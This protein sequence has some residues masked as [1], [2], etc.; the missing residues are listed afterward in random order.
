[1]QMLPPQV[2]LD[3]IWVIL[4]LATLAVALLTCNRRTAETARSNAPKAALR[5][6]ATG[7]S[8]PLGRHQ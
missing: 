5:S 1:M 3:L 2:E 7:P 8:R 6:Q 4:A